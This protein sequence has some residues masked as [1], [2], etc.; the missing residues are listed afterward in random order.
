[1]NFQFWATQPRLLAARLRYWIWEKLNP[2]KPWLCPGTIAFCEASLA[3]T[4]ASLT[5]VEHDE[6]W[7]REIRAQLAQ[8]QVTN[9]DYL[10]VPLEHPLSAPE[11]SSY[12]PV[13]QYVKVADRFAD[14]GLDFIVVD[15]HYRTTCIRHVAR[16]LSPGGYL[17]LDDAQRWTN[18]A[19]LGVPSS[20]RI[21]NDSSNGLKRCIIWQAA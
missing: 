11:R 12:D 17:L 3:K 7:Y 5:S 4:M 14:H 15:G 18:L 21:V 13:P 9:V 2:G 8:A 1:M 16:K 6:R 10:N 19:D 20:W